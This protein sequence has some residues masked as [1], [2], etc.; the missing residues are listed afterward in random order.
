[1]NFDSFYYVV[2]DKL[3][4]LKSDNLKIQEEKYKR[5]SES[6]NNLYNLNETRMEEVLGEKK[7]AAKISRNFTQN[8]KLKYKFDTR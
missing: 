2:K 5:L 3:K 6:L 1:M 8:E 7:T 4:Q